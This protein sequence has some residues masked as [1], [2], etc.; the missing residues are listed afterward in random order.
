MMRLLLAA[1]I[2]YVLASPFAKAQEP[3]AERAVHH[4]DEWKTILE[5]GTL[6]YDA[7]SIVPVEGGFAIWTRSF[8]DKS[9]F[10]GTDWVLFEPAKGKWSAMMQEPYSSVMVGIH[11]DQI[12]RFQLAKYLPE[13]SVEVQIVNEGTHA[14]FLQH[15]GWNTFHHR[16]EFNIIDLSTYAITPL[17]LWCGS[18]APRKLVWDLPAEN[19]IIACS[20]LVWLEGE[21]VQIRMMADYLDAPYHGYIYLD[22]ISPDKRY[23]LLRAKSTPYNPSPS[24]FLLYDRIAQEYTILIDER[25]DVPGPYLFAWLDKSTVLINE[26]SYLLYYDAVTDERTKLLDKDALAMGDESLTMNQTLSHDGQWLLVVTFSGEA[27]LRNVYDAIE[28]HQKGSI[29]MG[30]L[31]P[32]PQNG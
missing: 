5:A 7:A 31:G 30:R 11:D 4:L 14:V 27:V 18:K 24:S 26:G 9:R 8:K 16:Y 20:L 2:L 13:E 23:W 17:S 19:L 22:S 21:D 10:S 28:A 6:S 1:I 25:W 12:A 32:R 15:A 29:A 3:A